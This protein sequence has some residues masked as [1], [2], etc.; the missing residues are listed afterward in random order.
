MPIENLLTITEYAKHRKTRNLPGQSYQAVSNALQAGRI[1]YHQVGKSK[2]IDPGKAD[3]AWDMFTDTRRYNST[4]MKD[5]TPQPPVSHVGTD[6]HRTL[7]Q[8]EA[9]QSCLES[10]TIV[11]GVLVK[12]LGL[13]P[14]EALRI[15]AQGVFTLTY[16]LGE[17]F[18]NHVFLHDFGVPE[19]M[20]ELT[21][22][23]LNCTAVTRALD[24]VSYFAKTLEDDTPMED[25]NLSIEQRDADIRRGMAALDIT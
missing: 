13:Q 21:Y 16:T 7:G 15:A 8:A 23:S 14:Q 12:E 25:D 19:W 2:L 3:Q 18:G 10:S 4:S 6:N 20:A 1:P 17:I 11:A 5:P 24:N 22:G 9:L